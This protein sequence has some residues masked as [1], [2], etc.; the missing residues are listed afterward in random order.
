MLYSRA[1]EI[2]NS[3]QRFTVLYQGNPIWIE[4]LNPKDKSA[5]ITDD[6]SQITVPVDAL[7]EK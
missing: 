5:L 2:L 7:L 1:Q 4:S 3:P 6:S